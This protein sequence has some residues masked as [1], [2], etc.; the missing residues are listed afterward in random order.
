MRKIANGGGSAAASFALN[1]F[2]SFS[3]WITYSSYHLEMCTNWCRD[4]T[5]LQAA[6]AA[7]LSMDFKLLFCM[8]SIIS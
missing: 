5:S 1:F 4:C 8:M 3:C 2:L 7:S 6:G